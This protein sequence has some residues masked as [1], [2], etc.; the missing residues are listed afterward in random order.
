MHKGIGD[1]VRSELC[2]RSVAFSIDTVP[3]LNHSGKPERF[4]A[5]P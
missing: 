4:T 3:K 5:F 2:T 1:V